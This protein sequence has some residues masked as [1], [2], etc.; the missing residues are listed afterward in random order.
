MFSSIDPEGWVG[1]ALGT[2]KEGLRDSI[3]CNLWIPSSLVAFPNQVLLRLWVVPGPGVP[4][5]GRTRSLVLAL[6]RA[7]PY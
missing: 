5:W 1:A 6:L 3:G 2:K 7:H 4:G